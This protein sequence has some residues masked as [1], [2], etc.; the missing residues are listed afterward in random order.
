MPFS[1]STSDLLSTCLG[2]DMTSTR[3]FVPALA[4][5]LTL[6]TPGAFA[7]A[8][9]ASPTAIVPAPPPPPPSLAP[10]QAQAAQALVQTFT[11]DPPAS[12]PLSLQIRT[13]E[14]LTLIL[15]AP[16]VLAQL[17]FT[18]AQVEALIAQVETIPTF[19]DDN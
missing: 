15:G 7:G 18:A 6:G 12:I 4:A 13:I 3:F 10:A 17:G 9:P 1:A 8:E 16:E 19:E 2:A 14:V 11:S 5:V